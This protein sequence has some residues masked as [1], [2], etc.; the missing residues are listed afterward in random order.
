MD[1]KVSKNTNYSIYIRFLA[2]TEPFLTNR[3]EFFMGAQETIIYILSIGVSN[4]GFGLY[5]GIL[6]FWAIKKGRGP[7]G[8]P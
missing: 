3:A 6:T 7:T 5:F 4:L 8:T 1:H 2:I